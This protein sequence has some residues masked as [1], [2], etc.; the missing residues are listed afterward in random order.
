MI[1][2]RQSKIKDVTNKTSAV[3][4]EDIKNVLEKNVHVSKIFILN[5]NQN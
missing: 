3:Q 4:P 2:E 1:S 5:F